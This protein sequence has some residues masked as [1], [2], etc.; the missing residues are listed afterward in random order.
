MAFGTRCDRFYIGA[1]TSGAA[2]GK[3]RQLDAMYDVADELPLSA[4]LKREYGACLPSPVISSRF[5]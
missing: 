3:R 4:E 5:V 2:K 1:I